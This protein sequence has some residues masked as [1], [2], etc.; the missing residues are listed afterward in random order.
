MN[1]SDQ[2]R[3][4]STLPVRTTLGTTAA[5]ASLL[6]ACSSGGGDGGGQQATF[7]SPTRST[8]IALTR[9]E[10][11]AIVANREADS[12]TILRVT[13]D[14]GADFFAI[15]VEIPVGD[16][17]RSVCLTPD[18]RLAFVSNGA[19]ATVS[20]IALQTGT[21]IA[22]IP[23]GSEPRGVV[24]TPNGQVVYVAEHTAGTVS[25]IDVAR[26]EVDRT[27]A[28]EGNP[29][30]LAITNDL[31]GDDADEIVFVT[32]FFAEPVPGGPGEGFD[33]GRQGVVWSFAVGGGAAS[34]IV[35]SPIANAGFAANRAAFCQEFN[36]NVHN[37]IFCP[38]VD[39]TDNT[40]PAIAADPQGAFPNQ[41][42]AAVL[43]NGRVYVPSIAAAPEPPVVFNV[44]VQSLVHVIDAQTDT[45]LAPLTVNL[46]AQVKLET[47]PATPQGSLV[48][49]FLNDVVDVE[50]NWPGDT[51]LFVSRGGNCVVRATLDANGAITLQAPNVVRYQTGN[52][53]GGITINAD[54]TRAYTCNEVGMSVTAIDL[55]N[56]V[57][58][59][60]DV[61][62]SDPP[63]PGSLTHRRLVGR[64][65]F[66]T[67]LGLPDQGA[68]GVAV[69][70]LVPLDHRN[71]ASDNG[72]S[73]C[74]SCHPDG[75][76]DNVTWIFGT[77]PRS[78]VPLD[79]FFAKTNPLDQ[80]ISNWSAVMGSVTDFNNNARGVQGGQGFA[81]QPPPASIF[82]HGIVQGGS[83]SLDLMTEWVQV[84]RPYEQ[85]DV[86]D[87]GALLAGSDVF[88]ANCAACHGGAKW[89]KSQVVYDNDPTFTSDPNAGGTPIDPGL[90]NAAAQVRS[91]TRPAIGGGTAT[92]TYLNGVGT[93]DPT[94]PIE[95]RGQ[96][97]ASGNPA[98][99]GLG[100]NA[101]SVLDVAYHGPYLH[102]GSARTIEDVFT[103]HALAAGTIET[104]L[105]DTQRSNLATFLRA[106]DAQTP[107][108]PSDTDAFLTDTP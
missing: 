77:G 4:R 29:T 64:L 102:D 36:A 49:L 48:R 85:P 2:L 16:E 104:Q 47:Q 86:A 15:V 95:L 99:G 18:D 60:R 73:S 42:H 33:D 45:Q 100:F 8:S 70:E 11:F 68:Q 43:R 107:T 44:N 6:A 83:D 14:A 40:A 82:Q 53:P 54:G 103:R 76:S 39:E 88:E 17:P 66:H 87:V 78:T 98:L 13:D 89:S 10:R 65:A 34:K 94:S 26:L 80:R 31:D 1:R 72:W 57:V 90:L 25:G 24:S 67:A 74:A 92:L 56:D 38:D 84:I 51:F 12:V 62:T 61:P 91:L 105:T 41:L 20:V 93:F 28:V 75:L 22:T 32:Q 30:G 55:V 46:N 19:D 23:V 7:G 63:L 3:H 35:L 58:L 96:G 59:V 101:P 81:G 79:A 37:E 21:V 71:K 27:I 50:A 5:L 108:F 97:A 52:L 9:D 106:I 69:R